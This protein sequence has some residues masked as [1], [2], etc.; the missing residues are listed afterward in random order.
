MKVLVV[1]DYHDSIY[2]LL[3]FNRLLNSINEHSSLESE[4]ELNVE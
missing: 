3:F 2:S 4:N 1:H